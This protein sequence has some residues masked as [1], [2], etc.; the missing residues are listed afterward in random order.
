MQRWQEIKVRQHRLKMEAEQTNVQ[1]VAH[2]EQIMKSGFSMSDIKGR[3][4]V[5]GSPVI[6]YLIEI[7]GLHRNYSEDAVEADEVMKR[8]QRTNKTMPAR[9]PRKGSLSRTLPQYD[10][11][12]GTYIVALLTSN[13]TILF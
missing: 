11:E 12:P 9:P 1:P 6:S 13:F 8:N 3:Y 4:V 5:W 2:I 7:V 10:M